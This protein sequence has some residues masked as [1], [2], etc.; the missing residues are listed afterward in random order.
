MKSEFR[1]HWVRLPTLFH[2]CETI[3]GVVRPGWADQ[4]LRSCVVDAMA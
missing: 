1:A 4:V 2:D 3:V